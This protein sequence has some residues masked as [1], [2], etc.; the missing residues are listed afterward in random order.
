M[1]G[2]FLSHASY[3]CATAQREVTAVVAEI[4]MYVLIVVLQLWLIL[5][6]VYCYKKIS[7]EQEAREARRALKAQTK[8]AHQVL[9]HAEYSL[10]MGVVAYRLC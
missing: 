7:A 10:S 4:L 8:Y 1:F 5:V 2:V 6:L 9:T 3:V